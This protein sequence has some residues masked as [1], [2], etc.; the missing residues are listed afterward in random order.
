[1]E[2]NKKNPPKEFVVPEGFDFTDS[3]AVLRLL[4]ADKSENS[5][6]EEVD[7]DEEQYFQPLLEILE[8]AAKLSK[9]SPAKCKTIDTGL[10][11]I[12]LIKDKRTALSKAF[13]ELNKSD[14]LS[15]VGYC[16]RC[17]ML[18]ERV[19]MDLLG[20]SCSGEVRDIVFAARLY[21][22]LDPDVNILDV[23]SRLILSSERC[24]AKLAMTMLLQQDVQT[25]ENAINLALF[26]CHKTKSG[27]KNFELLPPELSNLSESMKSKEPVLAKREKEL[28]LLQN[29]LCTMEKPN[30]LLVGPAGTGKS[31]IVEY[32]AYLLAL[33]KASPMLEGKKIYQLDMASFVAGSKYVGELESKFIRLMNNVLSLENAILFVDEAHTIV[34]AGQGMNSNTDVAQLLK[35]YLARGDIRMVGA[36][37]AEEYDRIIKKDA[38]FKR[39][40]QVIEVLE[41]SIPDTI[42]M[43]SMQKAKRESFYNVVI[44]EKLVPFIVSL[45]NEKIK[46]Y[47]FPDKAVSVM[48]TACVNAIAE[49]Q[50]RTQIMEVKQKHVENVFEK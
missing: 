13:Y 36:T 25:L 45:A 21:H 15:V 19:P 37:T 23:V 12:S 8:E 22:Q 24:N 6:K 14:I 33:N 38:A 46:D 1:M 28:K 39:R 40:F 41:P 43:V 44:D 34:G 7:L 30:A 20:Y 2:K 9:S 16:A 29:A 27:S 11:L 48:D 3:E 26:S 32:L 4:T 42:D 35:P 5:S 49:R 47:A 31:A 18:G 10:I 17:S 50:D